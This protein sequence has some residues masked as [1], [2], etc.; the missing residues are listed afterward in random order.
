MPSLFKN[1]NVGKNV[2]TP[3]DRMIILKVQKISNI[4]ECSERY[5]L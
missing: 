3:N 2:N 1:V 5:Y 4:S